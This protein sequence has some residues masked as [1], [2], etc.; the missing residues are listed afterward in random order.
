MMASEKSAWYL[1]IARSSRELMTACRMRL[2]EGVWKR[3]WMAASERGKRWSR[4]AAK[5]TRAPESELPTNV[6]QM[7]TAMPMVTSAAPAE[8]AMRRSASAVGLLEDAMTAAGRM[9]WT[10]LCKSM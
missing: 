1:P 2:A 5:G 4:A 9:Y 6:A 7:L 3:G 10:A 8:P